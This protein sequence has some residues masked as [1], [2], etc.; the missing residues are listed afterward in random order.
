MSHIWPCMWPY[1]SL[2]MALHGLICPCIPSYALNIQGRLSYVYGLICI[3]PYILCGITSL[4]QISFSVHIIWP[5]MLYMALYVVYGLICIWPYILCGI[6]SL[7]E[8]SFSLIQISFSFIEF[9]PVQC[10]YNLALYVVHGLICIWAYMYNG[11]ISYV[12]E[13]AQFR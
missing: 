5:Y 8:I 10:T 1:M 4:A 3:W 2:Y 6:T 11:L 12:A 7:L 9:N 13:R